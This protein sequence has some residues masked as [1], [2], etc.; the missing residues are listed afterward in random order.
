ML[1][2]TYF[3]K[4]FWSSQQFTIARSINF[5]LISVS[6]MS[7]S[8]APSSDSTD[9][10]MSIIAT[11]VSVSSSDNNPSEIAS[12]TSPESAPE[13]APENAPDSI[14]IADDSVDTVVEGEMDLDAGSS[15]WSR[16]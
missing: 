10:D 6:Q 12:Q 15:V 8:E 5:A 16:G 4:M 11:P 1:V 2:F 14:P 3:K 9:T 7:K 13:N